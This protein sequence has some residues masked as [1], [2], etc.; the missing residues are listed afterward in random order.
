MTLNTDST[1]PEPIINSGA[2][3]AMMS[4]KSVHSTAPCSIAPLDAAND[5]KHV[6]N[7]PD[8]ATTLTNVLFCAV[9]FNTFVADSK[10]P[11]LPPCF[12]IH[13]VTA[14][15][16][17]CLT[18]RAIFSLHSVFGGQTCVEYKG[19]REK[20]KWIVLIYK[21]FFLDLIYATFLRVK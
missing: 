12:L 5:P 7:A 3:C 4:N 17:P 16:P 21:S 13:S 15:I 6:C 9:R 18:A 8:D 1:I 11:S 2:F 14:S 10:R 19:I 20:K